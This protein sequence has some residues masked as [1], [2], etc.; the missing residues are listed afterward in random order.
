MSVR[1]LPWLW[2]FLGLVL[3]GGFAWLTRHPDS[4][5][6]ERAARW[7]VV[8]GAAARFRA[9]YLPPPAPAADLRPAPTIVVRLPPDAQDL[10]ARPFVWAGPGAALRDAPSLDSPPVEGLE[11]AANLPVLEERPGWVRVRLR[12]R[13]LW[14]ARRE[15]ADPGPA[16]ALPL[17]EPV[18]PLPGR[19]ADPV[20]LAHAL[21]LLGERRRQLPLGG[22][23]L[24]TD[25]VDAALLALC[26]RVAAAL[27]DL[28]RHRYGLEL[29]GG[30]AETIVLFAEEAAYRELERREE[31]VAGLG[32]S[33]F[34]GHGLVALFG[35]DRPAEE[36]AATLAHEV[37][38]LLNRRGLGPAL[39]PWLDEGLSD[40]LAQSRI[41][42]E[43]GLV[44]GTL[45]GRVLRTPE[46]IDLRG[47]RASAL[48]LQRGFDAGSVPPLEELLA[49]DWEAFVRPQG[50]ELRYAAS[51]FLVRYLLAAEGGALASGLRDFLRDVAGGGPATGEALRAR[52]GRPWPQL[53]LGF[54][55]WV[56]S[57]PL[58]G[59]AVAA[60]AELPR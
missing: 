37:V 38:H 5:W 41:D 52:L 16:S 45:G 48:E 43:A 23:A 2:V 50:R 3:F 19:S 34:S 15:L 32:A 14:V 59:E 18:R 17:V 44:P 11:A 30:A 57:L 22:Y 8:G 12:G 13:Q 28:Y 42:P 58:D 9:L 24:H 27:E 49:L 55:A 51:Q 54:R 40:D 21:E 39:P 29:V 35:G 53:E 1:R 25:V 10:D 26:E 47:A 36:V 46:R 4:P 31:R 56:R 60:G 7:P 33:G 6:L 20:L